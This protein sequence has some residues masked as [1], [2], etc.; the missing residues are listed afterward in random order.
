MP[1]ILRST[2]LNKSAAQVLF[3]KTPF[4]PLVYYDADNKIKVRFNPGF[5]INYQSQEGEKIADNTQFILRPSNMDESFLIESGN[6]FYLELTTSRSAPVSMT[7]V[8]LGEEDGEPE[9]NDKFHFGSINV[10]TDGYEQEEGVYRIPLCAI[11]SDTGIIKEVCL[12][13]NIH[14]QKS[15]YE[16]MQG[17]DARVLKTIGV[18]PDR[19]GSDPATQFRAVLGIYPIIVT[20]TPDTINIGIDLDGDGTT[21]VPIPPYDPPTPYPP[22]DPPYTPPIFTDPDGSG[23]TCI[24]GVDKKFKESGFTALFNLE[25]PEVRFDDIITADITGVETY[26][27]ID[28]LFLEVCEKGTVEVSSIVANNASRVGAE[29]KG[30]H[31]VVRSSL[32]KFLRPDKVTIRINGIR[33]GFKGYRFPS[34]TR[35]QYEANE[36]FIKKAYANI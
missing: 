1:D 25:M 24:V 10:A 4:W 27:P 17:G 21:D 23:K 5:L 6:E 19:Y 22:Y 28:P 20:E 32:F 8:Q 34:K 18:E 29:V 13:E 14:W 36:R 26:V 33:R 2:V 12:R 7:I 35:E 9:S 15:H 11:D 16:N 3:E 30:D 31:I